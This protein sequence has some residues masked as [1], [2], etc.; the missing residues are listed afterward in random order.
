MRYAN[1]IKIP[2]LIKR[3]IGSSFDLIKQNQLQ[4]S[5]VTIIFK[6]ITKKPLFIRTGYDV[7]E[8]AKKNNKKKSRLLLI[9]LY[10]QISL[11]LADIYTVSSFSDLNNLKKFFKTKKNLHYLP[12]WV[13]VPEFVPYQERSKNDI[14][15]VG[16][17]ENQKNLRLLIDKLKN[18]QLNSIH[19]GDGSLKKSLLKHAKK[20]GVEFKLKEP[21]NN[22]YLINEY[23][24]YI[25]Y[26]SPSYFEGNSKTILEAMAAGCIVLA[27][28]I[29]N[30]RE[31]IRDN[32]NGFLIPLKNFEINKIVENLSKDLDHAAEIGAS[33][34]NTILENFS[35]DKLL[36]QEYELLKKII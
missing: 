11:L 12:N 30:N 29:E 27:S 22:S 4:G 21:I 34:R 33:A 15:S 36:N 25:F 20:I 23:S 14:F 35:L 9:F 28:D 7:F 24:K 19:I 17:L 6:I 10:Q 8:F 31:L 18:T 16:R 3:L 5:L 2:L 1:S 32:E 26:A 13:L